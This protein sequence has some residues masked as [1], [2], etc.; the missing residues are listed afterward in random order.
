MP[1]ESI[2]LAQAPL[3]ELQPLQKVLQQAS[4]D[5]TIMCPPGTDPNG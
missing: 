3:K 5:S 1:D 2:I 4:I